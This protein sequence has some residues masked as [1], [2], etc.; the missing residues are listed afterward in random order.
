MMP[1]RHHRFR[2]AVA[3]AAIGVLALTGCGAPEFA[4]VKNSE[5]KTYFKVPSS[6]GQ[7]D[8]GSL[9]SY[10][11]GEEGSAQSRVNQETIWSVAYDAARPPA[12]DHIFGFTKTDDPVVWAKVEELQPQQADMVSNDVLRNLVLPVTADARQASTQGGSLMADFELLH[13]EVLNPEKGLRGV[14]VIYNY[15]LPAGGLHTFD[16]TVLVDDA[17]TALY[18]LLLRCSATCYVDRMDE[19]QEV[20]TSF[21]VRSS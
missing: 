1:A 13:D 9:D 17:G 10:V 4:Y 2:T 8:Q 21:T 14:R 6:W 11:N 7:V 19:I 18:L 5:H 16:Q 20:V 15:S 12:V 3:L